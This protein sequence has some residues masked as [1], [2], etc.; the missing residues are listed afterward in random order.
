MGA[1]DLDFTFRPGEGLPSSAFERVRALGPVAWS[2]GLGAWVVSSYAAVKTVLSDTGRFTSEGTPVQE[3]FGRE[4]MLVDDTPRHHT[5]RA[6]WARHVSP[7]ALARRAET[8][9]EIA[10]RS[11][12]PAAGRLDAGETVEMVEVFQ[13]FVTEVIA[14]MFEVPRAC[15][16]DLKRWNTMFANAP[17][18]GGAQDEV[19]RARHMQARAEAY[20][21]LESVMQDRRDRAAAGERLQDFI[22]LMVA[23]EGTS[24]ITRQMAADNLL[25]FFLGALDT[26]VKWLGAVV[27]FLAERRDVLAEI[28]ARRELLAPVMEE[29]MRLETVAQ[30]LM[31]IVRADT[32]LMGVS[33]RAHDRVMVLLGAANRDPAAFAD[34]DAFRL[35]RAGELHLGFGFGWHHCLGASVA[36]EETRAFLQVLVDRLP[37]FEVTGV[38]YGD[39]WAVWGPRSLR[40]KGGVTPPAP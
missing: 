30:S 21:F 32:E 18:L 6:V 14:W 31:R 7:Q 34:P 5:V 33:L 35:D 19:R 40:L 20:G 37:G 9:Q 16:G 29:V 13:D 38:D 8:L 17:A 28:Q 10:A 39:S 2:E 25:N 12:A 11:L 4:A 22:S 23:A 1:A 36:R 3:A 27:L 24:G 26:T 15:V